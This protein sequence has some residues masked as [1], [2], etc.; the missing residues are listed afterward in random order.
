MEKQKG[1]HIDEFKEGEII[2]KLEPTII[3]LEFEKN[4]LTGKFVS[5]RSN[6]DYSFTFHPMIYKGICNNQIC[7]EYTEDY[8]KGKLINANYNLY[9]HGWARYIDP[10]ILEEPEPRMLN[11][12][13]AQSFLED[14]IRDYSN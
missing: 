11:K 3:P 5:T 14:C 13:D 10:K 7:L 12:K 1:K 4:D 8:L 9:Q 6:L 2:I